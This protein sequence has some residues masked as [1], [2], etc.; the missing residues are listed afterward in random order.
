MLKTKLYDNSITGDL[1]LHDHD[2]S[3]KLVQ[4]TVY[5]RLVL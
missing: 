1:I 4:P 2:G 5:G 3:I